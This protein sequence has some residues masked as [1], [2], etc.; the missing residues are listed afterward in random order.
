[1]DYIADL[2]REQHE[3]VMNVLR[4]G[5]HLSPELAETSA[6]A[7]R[8]IQAHMV[9][10]IHAAATD[11]GGKWNA[12]SFYNAASKYGRNAADAFK[13]RPDVLKNL[14][15]INE[16]G[17]HLHMDKSYPGA[18]AQKERVSKIGH[19][20]EAGGKVASSLV[21]DV[22]FVGRYVGRAIEGG[23]EGL[24]GKMS[25]ADREKAVAKRIVDRNGKQRGSVRV[26]NDERENNA[27]GESAA[28]L[29]AQNRNR[30]EL[31][32]G[33]TRHLIDPDGNVTPLTGVDAVD[34]AAPKG[35]VI[36]QKGVGILDRGGLPQGQAA[37]LVNRA[38][39][40]GFDTEAKAPGATL[41]IGRPHLLSAAER[42]EQ[43]RQERR[44][45]G[46]KAPKD[47]E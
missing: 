22:P 37:G 18:F 2:P 40:G 26:M 15:T 41:N 42:L 12:R 4:A 46:K 23:V 34:R 17:N 38:K 33:R 44:A 14:Q 11:D 29:E 30:D 9:S 8:E 45:A 16:A 19:A 47:E 24:A 3:H 27:S 39:A 20:L 43:V 7:I 36:Y 32:A 31:N 25:E 28:S 21:H 35:H 10:R 5:A 1:M 13:E 6:Q